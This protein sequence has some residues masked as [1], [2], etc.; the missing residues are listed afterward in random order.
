M[1]LNYVTEK[2]ICSV[3][4]EKA[5]AGDRSLPLMG[6]RAHIDHRQISPYRRFP[7]PRNT[8]SSP[9]TGPCL[10][11]V[12]DPAFSSLSRRFYN[13]NLPGKLTVFS[14]TSNSSSAL[15]LSSLSSSPIP[16][17]TILQ[18][19]ISRKGCCCWSAPSPV[20]QRWT[21]HSLPGPAAPVTPRCGAGPEDPK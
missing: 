17:C 2:L 1:T 19:Y 20:A 12:S 8:G 10:K 5:I 16:R 7:L 15:T 6:P 13:T 18:I 14:K 9:E 21:G 3:T 4:G 11:E